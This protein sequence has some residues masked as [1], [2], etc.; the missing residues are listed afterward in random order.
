VTALSNDAIRRLRDVVELPDLSNTRYEPVE[1]VARGGMG[2]VFRARDRELNREV[3]LKVLSTVHL[4]DDARARMLREARVLARLEHPGIVPVHDVGTLPDG[5][6]FYTMKLVRGSRL[7]DYART[8]R[9][10]NDL[11]RVFLRVCEA[12]AFAHAEGVVHRDLKP[13][14]IMVGA[15]GEVLVM[16]WGVAKILGAADGAES[17]PGAAEKPAARG[18]GESTAT[19]SVLGTPGYM[20]P[21]QERGETALV[22]RRSDVFALGALLRYLAESASGTAG[23]PRRLRAIHE[24]ASAPEAAERYQRVEALCEDMNRYMTGLSVSAYREPW[25][26]RAA[27]LARRHRTAIVLVLTYLLMR[28]LVFLADRF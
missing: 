28:I 9:D 22:D 24:R 5:R 1:F 23:V 21:E 4:S 20:A 14:N 26:E 18:A 25:Y 16:D 2:V 10:L 11:L 7:D 27:R 19:G 6:V 13:G 3:A 17:A 8:H 12:V 15:F